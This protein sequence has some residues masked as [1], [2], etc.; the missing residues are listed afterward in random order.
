MMNPTPTLNN[1]FS[2][3]KI[4]TEL[5][6]L[7]GGILMIP[8]GQQKPMKPAK[9]NSYVR[10]PPRSIRRPL[11]HARTLAAFLRDSRRRSSQDPSHAAL[12]RTV[13]PHPRRDLVCTSS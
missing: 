3:Q 6:Y 8:S 5:D 1:K 2:F 10:A 13:S 7:A 9:D 12:R 4:Y 11:A